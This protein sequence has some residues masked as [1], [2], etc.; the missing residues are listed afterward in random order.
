MLGFWVMVFLRWHFVLRYQVNSIGL[1]PG[2]PPGLPWQWRGKEVNLLLRID[3]LGDG[4]VLMT[5][6]LICA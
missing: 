1:V 4:L 3:L 6:L 5:L 2:P